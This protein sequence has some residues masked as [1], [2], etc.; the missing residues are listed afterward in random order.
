MLN[1]S[2]KHI[3]SFIIFICI[4]FNCYSNGAG[5]QFSAIPSTEGITADVKGTMRLMELPLSF[6]FG[7]EC[8]SRN[9]EFKLGLSGYSDYWLL[10]LQLYNTLS[11]FAGPGIG[12]HVLTDNDLNF[13]GIAGLRA[14]IGFDWL[15]YDHYLEL[16]AQGG[17]E[18]GIAVPFS[19]PESSQFNLNFP[20]EI[21]LRVH[22]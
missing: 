2:K 18:P 6:G 8:G 5:I 16:F 11:F 14:I 3:F 9:D 7:F 21:G 17:V 13:S 19:N 1:N 12:I 20:C 15:F 4:S 10:D 22:F